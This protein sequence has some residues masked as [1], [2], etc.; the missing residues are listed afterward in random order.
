MKL[1]A[2][3]EL[4]SR[5]A[6][7]REARRMTREQLARLLG[8]SPGPQERSGWSARTITRIET[9][10][11]GMSTSDQIVL[12]KVLRGPADMFQSAEAFDRWLTSL[13]TESVNMADPLG[14]PSESVAGD[15][16]R[17][18]AKAL[19]ILREQPEYRAVVGPAFTELLGGRT[20]HG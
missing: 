19:D 7:A 16:L 15:D 20:V 11:R 18:L 8:W 6:T 1:D 10:V 2:S 9:G 13:P 14:L 17:V 4:G 3:K 12:C 5:L